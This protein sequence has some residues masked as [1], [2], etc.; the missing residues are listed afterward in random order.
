MQFS[1]RLYFRVRVRVR[2][3]V[4]VRIRLSLGLG[5][6]KLNLQ[7]ISSGASTKLHLTPIFKRNMISGFLV[8]GK[9]ARLGRNQA[10]THRI[11]EK[12]VTTW[13]FRPRVIWISPSVDNF[14]FL[15]FPARTP[16]IS[17]INT[18][19]R[20]KILTTYLT[21][22]TSLIFFSGWVYIEAK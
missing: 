22:V 6:G 1:G 13:A 20:S 8:V 5:F 17:K 14:R 3:W 2:V 4:R 12:L 18:I 9:N 16:T 11:L 7:L 15:P 19:S 10:A 21:E